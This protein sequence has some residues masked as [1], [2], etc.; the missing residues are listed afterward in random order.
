MHVRTFLLCFFLLCVCVTSNYS[1]LFKSLIRNNT[2]HKHWLETLRYLQF[3]KADLPV[4]LAFMSI[5]CES[6]EISLLGTKITIDGCPDSME[7]YILGFTWIS[8]NMF[9][10]EMKGS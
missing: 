10:L 1:R 6:F 3:F 9:C 4:E 7:C 2:N 8:S 5:I